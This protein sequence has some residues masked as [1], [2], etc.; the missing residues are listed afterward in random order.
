MVRKGRLSASW[1]ELVSDGAGG[2]LPASVPMK[3]MVNQAQSTLPPP[4]SLLLE[5]VHPRIPTN[6][7][8]VQYFRCGCKGLHGLSLTYWSLRLGCH[9]RSPIQC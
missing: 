4:G 8:S 2:C 1:L 5:A 7:G 6:G 9:A 3:R